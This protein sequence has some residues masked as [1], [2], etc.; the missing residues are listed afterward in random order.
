MWHAKEGV[1]TEEALWHWRHPHA[2]L[3]MAVPGLRGYVQD[4]CS[5]SP[6]GG[7]VAY[8]GVGEVWFDDFESATTAIRSPEWAAVVADAASFIDLDSI[9]AVWAEEHRI[10]PPA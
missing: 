3:V 8:T 1:S 10:L 4:H 2:E 6:E 7:E 5:E 9:V